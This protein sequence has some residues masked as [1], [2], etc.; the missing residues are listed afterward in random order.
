M[1]RIR[2]IAAIVALQALPISNAVSQGAMRVAPSGHAITEVTL[3]LVDSVA[4]AAAKPAVIRID[5]GQPHL[6]GRMLHTDS[7]L[8]YDS[9]W[10]TG[11]NAPTTLTTDVDLVVGGANIPKGTYLLRSL[12]RRSGWTLIVEKDTRSS[13]AGNLPDYKRENDV[14]RI[15][16]Q[17]TSR[18]AAL[19]SF[20][21]WLIPSREP[22]TPRGELVMAWG[23]TVL[24]T[25]WSMR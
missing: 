10:R 12:P 15:E 23:T 13:P 14:A 3:T 2:H 24:S 5:Y 16:L 6:R 20:T 9:V 8:P 22:G 25:P 7:L 17:R 19:E 18:A 21:M 4:R 1:L 11:A